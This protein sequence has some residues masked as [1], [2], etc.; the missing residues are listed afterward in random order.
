MIVTEEQSFGLDDMDFDSFYPGED[1]ENIYILE[2]FKN[3]VPIA[4]PLVDSEI[5][6]SNMLI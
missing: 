6:L 1:F 2:P 3:I 4:L 5:I